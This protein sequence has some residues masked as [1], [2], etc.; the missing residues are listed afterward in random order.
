VKRSAQ[1]MRKLLAQPSSDNLSSLL[2]LASGAS[3]MRRE[4]IQLS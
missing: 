4:N 1:N 2:D 3:S